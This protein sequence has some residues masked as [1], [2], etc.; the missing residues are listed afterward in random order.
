M[1]PAPLLFGLEGS[2]CWSWCSLLPQVVQARTG[3]LRGVRGVVTRSR[4]DVGGEVVVPATGADGEFGSITSKAFHHL[5]LV[6]AR[7]RF[8]RLPATG[9]VLTRG[10][11]KANFHG[12]TEL[13][14]CS[15][16]RIVGTRAGHHATAGRAAVVA[17][18]GSEHLTISDGAAQFV[19]T[20]TWGI[21]LSRQVCAEA[22]SE[23]DARAPLQAWVPR[24]SVVSWSR[25]LLHRVLAEAEPG[26]SAKTE[27]RLGLVLAH[28]VALRGFRHVA[29]RPGGRARTKEA[30]R[31]DAA[32]HGEGGPSFA[33]GEQGGVWW[34][35]RA[36]LAAHA[37]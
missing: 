20:R 1:V 5:H 28:L 31:G 6:G 33:L 8:G 3:E 7:S 18:A 11:A 13:R 30:S 21:G 17:A 27:P 9:E 16:G 19:S 35:A 32:P 12:G 29:A 36:V 22:A 24:I 15:I 26:S 25:P 14:L 37:R 2:K 4:L 10:C 34:W 23:A